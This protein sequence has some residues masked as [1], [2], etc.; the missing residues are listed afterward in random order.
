[1]K[2]VLNIRQFHS[3]RGDITSFPLADLL[4]H[5]RLAAPSDEFILIS[6]R[7]IRQAAF[8]DLKVYILAPKA[9]NELLSKYWFDVKLTSFLKR[10]KADVFVSF[11]DR[12]SLKSQIPRVI[13][14]TDHLQTKRSLAKFLSKAESI[15]TFSEFHKKKLIDQM[16]IQRGIITML[17]TMTVPDYKPLNFVEKERVK[18]MAA[19]G[20]EYFLCNSIEDEIAMMNV[21]KAFSLF[22]KRQRSEMKMLVHGWLPDQVANKLRTYKY[23]EDVLVL[24]DDAPEYPLLLGACYCVIQL[25]E[26]IHSIPQAFH[27]AVPMI[28][29]SENVTK[30]I[31]RGAALYTNNDPVDLADK[32]MR[33][34]KDERLRFEIL[35]SGKIHASSYS[36]RKT[37]DI[38]WDVIRSANTD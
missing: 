4:S 13:I 3:Y 21:L 17:P 9:T 6:D 27:S 18:Q 5:L 24:E 26:N 28:L 33:I 10:E 23:R 2:I 36:M 31:S 20:K 12:C 19:E 30:E 8:G 37:A 15:I 1:M 22:K 35:E 32:M 7:E 38:L 29:L 16:N 11:N 25:D 14:L 34:Y